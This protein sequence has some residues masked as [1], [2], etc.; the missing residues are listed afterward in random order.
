MTL[1]TAVETAIAD[2]APEIIVIDVEEPAVD[3]GDI[4]VTTPVELGRRPA[5]GVR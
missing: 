3:V 2:A 1:R 4:G 5:V